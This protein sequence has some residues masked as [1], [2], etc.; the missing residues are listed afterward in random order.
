MEAQNNKRPRV[1][2]RMPA[3]E[4]STTSEPASECRPRS[5][6]LPIQFEPL[7]STQTSNHNARYTVPEPSRPPRRYSSYTAEECLAMWPNYEKS[8]IVQELI[9]EDLPVVEGETY[10]SGLT[11]A[12]ILEALTQ[13][14]KARR[15]AR[16]ERRKSENATSSKEEED[17]Q[18]GPIEYMI[19]TDEDNKAVAAMREWK[20]PESD[21]PTKNPPEESRSPKWKPKELSP[22]FDP[23]MMLKIPQTAYASPPRNSGLSPTAP[24]Y[25]PATNSCS[26]NPL[27]RYS[28]T[29]PTTQPGI[30]WPPKSTSSQSAPS[31]RAPYQPPTS[32]P[33]PSYQSPFS[34]SASTASQGTTE[35]RDPPIA[36]PLACSITS[37]T[38]SSSSEPQEGGS[39]LQQS[40]DHNAEQSSQTTSSQHLQTHATR[41]TE[42]QSSCTPS[43]PKKPRVK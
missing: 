43:P 38:G 1:V 9:A 28:P 17:R 19:V 31:I 10:P 36:H 24:N 4:N 8:I 26:A 21:E 42:S 39:K 11:G 33:A 3:G 7:E 6:V 29:D 27:G 15:K 32:T 34:A 14:E 2:L 41:A 5:P 35:R 37:S 40:N 13:R 16:R 22:L 30:N 23:T 20:W 18:P 25:R 12:E